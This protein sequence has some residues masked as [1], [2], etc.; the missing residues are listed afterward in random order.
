MPGGAADRDRLAVTGLV[1]QIA[2][3]LDQHL[4]RVADQGAVLLQRDPLL[5]LQQRCPPLLGDLRRHRVR[6]PGTGGGRLV[7]VREDAD[8]I[9]LDLGY[10]VVQ[11]PELLVGLAG[12]AHDECGT[13]HRAVE[14]LPGIAED[15][16]IQVHVARARHRAQDVRVGVLDRHVQVRHA[17]GRLGHR[18]DQ[19]EDEL[20]GVDV[21]H[22]KPAQCRYLLGDQ[23]DEPRQ[24]VLDAEVGSVADGVLRDQD[25]LLDSSVDQ[26]PDLAHHIERSLAGLAA[27]DERDGA[28]GA[29]VIAAVGDLDVGAGTGRTCPAEAGEHRRPVV[30][31]YWGGRDVEQPADDLADLGP[32]AGRE[33]GVD[34]GR[35]LGPVLVERGHTA[36]G[37]H[38]L[39]RP[40][41]LEQ[42]LD[43]LGRLAPGA[44]QEAAGVD[45]Q[46]LSVLGLLG[47][48]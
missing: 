34:A 18:I 13:E 29:C 35:D 8:V 45:D 1:L 32:L 15:A 21:E 19:P 31:V 26:L 43:C 25:N 7:G 2:H 17:G 5:E 39:A 10:E 46:H 11:A 40:P 22:A 30:R 6:Q 41:G 38:Q 44:G 20:A 12:E 3:A 47:W 9:E 24:A 36:R 48:R 27:L 23:A 28:E 33:D 16:P 4:E 14:L 42:L 37:D